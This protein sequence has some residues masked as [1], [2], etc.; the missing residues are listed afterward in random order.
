MLSCV[1]RL[2]EVAFHF[3]FTY[4]SM[5]GGAQGV[6]GLSQLAGLYL[7]HSVSAAQDCVAQTHNNK[8]ES[9]IALQACQITRIGM[10]QGGG[11]CW[12]HAP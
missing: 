5:L 7:D 2:D 10:Q 1:S 9:K 6:N 12:W 4:Y 8:T 11:I 3:S